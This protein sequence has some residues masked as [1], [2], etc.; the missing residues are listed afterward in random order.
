MPDRVKISKR[1]ALPKVDPEMQRWCAVLEEEIAT[2]P[3]VNDKPMFGMTAFYR[4]KT[5]FAVLPRTRA[6]ETPF[7]L[8]VKIPPRSPRLRKASGPGAGWVTF[9]MESEEDLTEAL[10]V[11]GR[12][13]ELARTRRT[14]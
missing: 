10:R 13:Y 12:A 5:I 2:W 1:P 11:L 14:R 3:G 6:A 7:S 8:L 9:A 4:G